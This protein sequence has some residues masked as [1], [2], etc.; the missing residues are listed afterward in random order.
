MKLVDYA[1]MQ[2]EGRG[3]LMIDGDQVCAQDLM[4]NPGAESWVRFDGEGQL[5]C[6]EC[7]GVVQVQGWKANRSRAFVNDRPA[8]HG[9]VKT[10]R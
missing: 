10:E 9:S 7:G 5:R 6:N 8:F 3:E 4:D 1:C 2:C